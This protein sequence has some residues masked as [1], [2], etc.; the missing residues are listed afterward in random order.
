M[1]PL[2]HLE[3]QPGSPQ[4]GD[5]VTF[6]FDKNAVT[7][8]TPLSVAWFDGLAVQYS[9]LKDGKATVPAGLQ[10]TVYAAVVNEQDGSPS[11]FDIA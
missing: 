2:P 5:A 3:I 1:T 6:K 7:S 10:G 9:D 4:P 11:A 8:D